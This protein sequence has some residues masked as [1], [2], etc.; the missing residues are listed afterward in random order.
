MVPN[1][2]GMALHADGGYVGTKPYAASANYINKMSDYCGKCFYDQKK[3]FGERACPFNS[4]YWDFMLRNAK[5]FA[6]NHRMSMI[7]KALSSKSSE[8]KAEIRKRAGELRQSG[9][10]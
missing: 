8:W 6:G 7:T 1:V 5:A 3:T 4:L 2:I 10:R 9:W